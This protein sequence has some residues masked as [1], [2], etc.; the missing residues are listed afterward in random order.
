MNIP[1]H[2]KEMVSFKRHNHYFLKNPMSTL[3]LNHINIRAT[4]ELLNELRDFYCS[5][6]DLVDGARPAMI[7]PG[8]WLYAR[9][10]PLALIHLSACKPGETRPSHQRNT[11][12]HVAF[13]CRDPDTMR[14]RLVA[15]GLDFTVKTLTDPMLLQMFFSDPAGNNIELNFPGAQ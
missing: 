14:A 6:L 13:T 1:Q 8:F 4:I 2:A 10:N 11:L 5:A 9:E 12:D 7:S 15:L 3:S